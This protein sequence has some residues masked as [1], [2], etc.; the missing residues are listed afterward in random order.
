MKVVWTF[1]MITFAVSLILS[2]GGVI[3]NSYSAAGIIS[4]LFNG[5]GNS[6]L[7]IALF[8]VGG[9]VTIM[10]AISIAN[11][12]TGGNASVGITAG[13]VAFAAYC[14]GLIGDWIS[15]INK[16]KTDVT[17]LSTQSICGVGYYIIYVYGVLM[18]IGFIFALVDLVGGN[19]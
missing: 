4:G 16:A 8:G 5:V 6:A 1:I 2:L 10:A 14:I 7:W 15:I 19:D 12:L 11:A 17:C 3:D 13:Y 18:V 9:V